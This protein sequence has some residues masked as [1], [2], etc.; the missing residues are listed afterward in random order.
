[1]FPATRNRLECS[2]VVNEREGYDYSVK[3][4]GTRSGC[5]IYATRPIGTP[6]MM[7]V[8]ASIL[9]MDDGGGC[10]RVVKAIGIKRP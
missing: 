1:M 8:R 5:G 3:L 4:G 7:A 9:S 6:A 10:W 2:L